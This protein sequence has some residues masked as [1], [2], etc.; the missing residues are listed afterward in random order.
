M[1]KW[2]FAAALVLV[3]GLAAP[4]GVGALTE[5]QWQQTQALLQQQ[6]MMTMETRRYERGYTGAE[7][8]GT[9]GFDSPDSGETLTLAYQ[10]EIR[11]G[12]W[13]SELTLRFGSTDDEWVQVLFPDQR[14]TLRADFKAWGSADLNFIL[15]AFEAVEPATGESIASS[16]LVLAGTLFDQGNGFDL[17]LDW[18]G[19]VARGPNATMT[20]NDV[21][22][23]QTMNRLRGD[24]WTGEAAL[25]VDRFTA[26]LEGEPEVSAQGL[27]IDSKTEAGADGERFTGVT[28]L[29]LNRVRSEGEEA[30]PFRMDFE[31]RDFQVDAWNRLLGAF[32]RLQM[33]AVAP[34]AGLSRQQRIEQQV[35]AMENLSAG[36]KSLAAA[37]MSF[38]FPSVSLSFPEGE[39]TGEV[40]LS[41]PELGADQ[42]DQLELVMQRLTGVMTWRLPAALVASEPAL[43]A[44]LAPLVEQGLVVREGDVYRVD[45][46]LQ[47][48]ELNVNG[49]IIPLPPM[50]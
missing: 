25:R 4:W 50:I 31:L 30:G 34:D 14:P 37:G 5:Q 15:P 29:T 11:H 17:T 10:G 9:L 22:M 21:T 46:R 39:V 40:M 28:G 13:G 35:Q 27:A 12:L 16:E 8:A 23:S 48:L 45:A 44:E 6:P 36:L 1:K 24:V 26:R 43:M 20:V 47:D 2:I 38:G 42:A 7:V 19:L 18:P 41:H 32:T 3:A 33:T 49:R